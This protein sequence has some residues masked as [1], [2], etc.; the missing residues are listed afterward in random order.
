MNELLKKDIT[1]KI[2]SI[3]FAIA[4]WYNVVDKNSN[5]IYPTSVSVPLEIL[6]KNSLDNKKIGLKDTNIP[7][8]VRLT[9][10]GRKDKLEAMRQFDFK[11]TIDLSEINSVTDKELKIKVIPNNPEIQVL[12]IE[13]ETVTLALEK[14][15]Q[16][17][18]KVG[19]KTSGVLKKNYQLINTNVIPDT[20]PIEGND[21]II[22]SIASVKAEVD[23]SDLDKNLTIEKECRFYNDKGEDISSS[24]KRNV[25]VK[26]QFEV[27][28]EIKVIP[29]V[30]GVP[31]K[32][33]VYSDLQAVPDKILV[34]G[35][36]DIL[37]SLYEIKAQSVNINNMTSST[38]IKSKLLLPKDI[39]PVDGST[40]IN[41]HVIIE[42]E[43]QKD[44][45]ISSE[46]ISVIYPNTS[47]SSRY[48]IM[49]QNISIS[50]KGKTTDLANIDINNLK[51]SINVAGLADNP[52]GT[53]KV[54]LSLNLPANV[55]PADNYQIEV[56]VEEIIE[57]PT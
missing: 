4:L 17:S 5:P 27:A 56:S 34:S 9:V 33:Y 39:S 8:N 12:T 46:N 50:L 28:K 41:V 10:R 44:L 29:D 20:V 26:I 37:S 49:P 6:N 40:D 52:T 2:I 21:S 15:I 36:P 22:K 43:G 32:N 7:P 57:E 35:P 55:R 45:T 54:P 53:Y 30:K 16:S 23:V 42:K 48:T 14:V 38:T 47:V 3:I 19:I 25:K 24:V 31:A 18:F 51:P 13:P 1:V 11:A